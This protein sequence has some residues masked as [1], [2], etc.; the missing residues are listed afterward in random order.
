M[1]Q[2]KEKGN[3]FCFQGDIVFF[4]DLNFLPDSN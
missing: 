4:F 2:A 3:S 1:E